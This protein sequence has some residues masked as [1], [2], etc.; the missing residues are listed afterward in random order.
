ME[1]TG[2]SP[3]EWEQL[4]SS[5]EGDAREVVR[6]LIFDLE[7]QQLAEQSASDERE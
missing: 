7:A 3:I 6:S 5:L 4:L 1:F 2:F